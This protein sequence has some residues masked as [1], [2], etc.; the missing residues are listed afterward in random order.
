MPFISSHSRRQFLKSLAATAAVSQGIIPLRASIVQPFLADAGTSPL[1]LDTSWEYYQGPLAGPWEVWH[2]EEIAVWEKVSLPHCFNHYDACDPETPY[3]RGHGW[4]R[5]GIS[6]ANP[7]KD[8]RTLLYFEGAGQS[9]YVYVGNTL[10]G[11]HIGGYDEFVFDITEALAAVD[12]ANRKD[13]VPIAV[14][15]D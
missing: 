4:Y 1:T 7:I 6:I 14:L 8:G 13:G 3:Y 2:G 10:V 9:S 12:A 15:C 5:T 11:S